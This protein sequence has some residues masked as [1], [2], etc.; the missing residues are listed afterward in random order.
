MGRRQGEKWKGEE[1]RK[2]REGEGK[3]GKYRRGRNLNT[4][5]SFY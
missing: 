3:R 5:S 2:G 1:G 4:A